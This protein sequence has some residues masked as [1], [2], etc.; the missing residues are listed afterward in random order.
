M[1]A[2]PALFSASIGR[3][4]PA[5]AEP[6][7]SE[8][9]AKGTTLHLT[10]GRRLH[11]VL[12]YADDGLPSHLVLA[13]AFADQDMLFTLAGGLKVP[14]AAVQPLRDALDGLLKDCRF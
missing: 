14:L 9:H 1:T 7:S 12:M 2:Q 5:A 8:L 4:T 3:P 10:G 11:A 6:E 13:T